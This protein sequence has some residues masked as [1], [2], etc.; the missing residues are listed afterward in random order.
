MT[1]TVESP[2]LKN[3]T[4]QLRL[5]K[6]VWRLAMPVM[7][8]NILQTLVEVIDVFMVGRISPM[9]I[10]AVG[11]SNTIR[12]L[13]MVMIL[14]VAAGSMS[15]IAQAK[16][17]RDSQRMSYV[18]RQA[19]SSGIMM[20]IAIGAIGFLLAQSLLS[21]TN[22]GGD[23]Q[24]VILG[25]PYLRLIFLGT[26][27]L[28][29]NVILNRMMQGAGDTLTPLYL[30]GSLNLMNIVFNYLLIF[31][32]G[33]FPELGLTG[34]AIGTVTA[35]GIGVLIAIAI[36]YS[37]KNVIHILPGSYRPDWQMFRDIFSIGVP[38]G[39][40]GV[41][42]NGS[43]LLVISIV[44]STEVATFG[45]AAIAIGYQVQALAIFPVLGINIA[46][47]NLVGEA[48]GRWQTDEARQRGNMTLM[49][50][51]VIMF[52]LALPMVI[53]APAI[54]SAFDPSSHPVVA[55]AGVSFLRITSLVLPLSALAM[56]ANGNL[57]GAG[58]TIPGMI[59]T[60]ITRATMTIGISY[61]LALVLDIGSVGVWIGIAAGMGLDALYM[62]WRWRS[63]IWMRVAL[64]KSEVY[65]QH[66][67]NLPPIV[68]ER[69]L[70]EVRAHYMFLDG[71]Q[72][73]VEQNAVRYTG[74]KCN[75]QV[76]F[77][78]DGYAIKQKPQSQ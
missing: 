4:S 74:P 9:A 5:L 48:L 31:G 1:Q 7:L 28:A 72:E 66:L 39:I 59:S 73:Q 56:V 58:D 65:R 21:L 77:A 63:N 23:P 6:Q 34:A 3:Q 70:E 12:M 67:R 71:T 49:L 25:T 11:M 16:G 15:L 45:A 62:G 22:S 38:S 13:V 43:R 8:A 41:F 55:E 32:I 40:Q 54:V 2:K 18:T 26:P 57:R 53:F 60:F 30:T 24:A 61:T 46:G 51:V 68:R 20:S 36:M 50:G 14:S 47:T 37:G 69:Y 78:D 64:Q 33:P 44:T 19:I 29:L 42:R 76:T 35:R 75:I 27:F 17:G 52:M 10:A